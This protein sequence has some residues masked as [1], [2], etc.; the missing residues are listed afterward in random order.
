M[1]APAVQTDIRG[2]I[3]TLRAIGS[4]EVPRHVGK[5]IAVTV[6]G[7][8]DWMRAETK[9]TLGARVRGPGGIVRH[10][11]PDYTINAIRS[12]NVEYRSLKGDSPNSQWRCFRRGQAGRARAGPESVPQISIRPGPAGPPTRERRP[13]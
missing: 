5:A 3:S 10:E 6:E 9:R 1:A 11:V 8:Q 7:A 13:S 12:T 4:T 2:A